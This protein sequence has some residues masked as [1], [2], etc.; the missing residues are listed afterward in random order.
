MNL[1]EPGIV[2]DAAGRRVAEV[3][4]GRAKPVLKAGVYFVRERL[5]NSDWRLAR[6]RKVVVL[7]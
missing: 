6:T 4:P 3:G 5:A 2:M 1:A 7:D